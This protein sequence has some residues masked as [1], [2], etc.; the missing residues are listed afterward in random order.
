MD[1]VDEREYEVALVISGYVNPGFDD[2]GEVECNGFVE[3]EDGN[4]NVAQHLKDGRL[5]FSVYAVNAQDAYDKAILLIDTADMGD[6]VVKDWNLEHV[7]GPDNSGK[8]KYW[9]KED[10]KTC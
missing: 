2:I 6:I 9:Y 8:D 1:K 5:Y 10:I 7:Y 3:C 4:G